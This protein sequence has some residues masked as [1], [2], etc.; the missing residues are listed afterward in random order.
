MSYAAIPNVPQQGISEWQFAFFNALKQNVEQ[1]TGQRGVP[2]YQ[3]ILV[4][5]VGVQPADVLQ[6]QQVTATG[7]GY[8]ISGSDVAALDDVA[9]LILDVQKVINDVQYLR[10]VLN[11]L[12]LQL[13]QQA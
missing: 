6:I 13:K 2:G 9:K 8:T 12:I 5:N 1:L 7:A 3:S 4:G 10:D 11:T